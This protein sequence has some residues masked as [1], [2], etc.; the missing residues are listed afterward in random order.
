MSI[1]PPLDD[2]GNV[3]IT[4][5]PSNFGGAIDCLF[6]NLGDGDFAYEGLTDLA[7][8]RTGLGIVVADFD[9]Q[10]GNEIFIGNDSLPNRLWKL[11][12]E[13]QSVGRQVDLAPVLGCAYGFSGGATGAMG[14]AVAD[15]DGD[16]RM[17][18][19]V[20]N[21]ENESSNLYIKRDRAFQDRNRQ[22]KLGESSREWVG[23]GTQAID[24]DHDSDVDLLVANGHLD[25]AISIRGTF[26]Q[27]LQLF[28]NRGRTF[29]ELEVTDDTGYWNAKHVGRSLA[30]LDF[31]RDGL[32]DVVMTNV[33][34]PSALILNRTRT[35]NHWLQVTL[36]GTLSDRDAVGAEVVVK[37][38]SGALHAWNVAGDGYLSSNEKVVSFGLGI[39]A[40]VERLTVRWPN[41]TTQ[42]FNDVA[43]DQ[44]LIVIE[45]EPL[46]F[47][48]H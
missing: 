32:T 15:F 28:C 5:A 34:E 31:D 2:N 14:I 47:L 25:D 27:P 11:G 45:N 46:L 3:S 29:E 48:Q 30:S 39:A 6:K 13:N 17:D 12:V 10:S 41:D 4:V 18:F 8:A 22:Y 7:D 24:Y 20:T 33:E 42:I 40:S 21:Y 44:R 16:S 38:T 43:V 9:Q 19:Y 35:P 23:F 37:L 26:A 1:K 36:V